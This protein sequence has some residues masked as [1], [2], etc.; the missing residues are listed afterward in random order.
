M[1]MLRYASLLAGAAVALLALGTLPATR[2]PAAAQEEQ[3]DMNK[4][5][6]CAATD[7]AGKQAC[8][9]GRDLIL[10]HCTACHTFVPIVMQQFDA[11][12]WQASIDRHQPRV[13]ELSHE[14]LQAIANYLS[15]NFN[16]ETPPPELPPD[17]LKNWTS[18]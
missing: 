15:A 3:V 12:A 5:F 2:Y 13:P 16:P 7:P 4:V 8:A 14:Q 11:K 18:Y 17:L 1:T 10:S 6:R 9:T